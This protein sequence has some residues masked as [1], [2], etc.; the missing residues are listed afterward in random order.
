MNF[1]SVHH[2]YKHLMSQIIKNISRPLTVGTVATLAS[3]VLGNDGYVLGMPSSVAYG[4]AAAG[5]SAIQEVSRDYVLNKITS[6]PATSTVAQFVAPALTGASM[7]GVMA[8]TDFVTGA[9]PNVSVLMQGLLIGAGAEVAGA[10]AQKTI[11]QP[12]LSGAYSSDS[13]LMF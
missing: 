7:I 3:F 4:L 10:W 1:F 13:V 5:A 2:V 8:L 6:D 9:S 12:V 11:V